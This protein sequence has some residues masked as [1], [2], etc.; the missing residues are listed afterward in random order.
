MR[1]LTVGARFAGIGGFDRGFERAGFTV[2]WRCEIDP[3]CQR[4]LR[5]YVPCVPIVDDVRTITATTVP[6]VDVLVGGFPCQDLSVAGQ[7]QGLHGDRSS[8][9]FE[10]VRVLHLLRPR[11]M[12]LENVPG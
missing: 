4:V 11:W 10:F 7:R 12:V 9:F 2:A 5:A 6:P 3:F 1:P 8:L